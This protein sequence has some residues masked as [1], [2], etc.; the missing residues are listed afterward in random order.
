MPSL[1]T[2]LPPTQHSPIFKRPLQHQDPTSP[3]CSPV[4]QQ[5][6][7]LTGNG[8]SSQPREILARLLEEFN[9]NLQPELARECTTERDVGVQQ[10]GTRPRQEG[11]R[12]RWS[13]Q[14][15][16]AKDIP[17][18]RCCDQKGRYFPFRLAVMTPLASWL[19][20]TTS[21]LSSRQMRFALLR[22]V[23]SYHFE[24]W[25]LGIKPY[26]ACLVTLTPCLPR[27]QYH[28]ITSCS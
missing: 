25:L 9:A 28:D 20:E 8:C 22:E 11:R 17:R 14:H 15:T 5:R 1:A 16:R 18:R 12:R 19:M 4:K 13:R 21:R 10:A 3:N 26:R 2:R 24:Y 6:S 7:Y 23:P 27:R